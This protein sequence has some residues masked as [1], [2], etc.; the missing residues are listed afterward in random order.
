[1]TNYDVTSH[2]AQLLPTREATPAAHFV[3]GSDRRHSP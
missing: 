3:L 1:M 2:Q